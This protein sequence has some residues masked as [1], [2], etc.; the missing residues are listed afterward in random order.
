MGLLTLAGF[1]GW[2]EESG[3]G[4]GGITCTVHT[5]NDVERLYIRMRLFKKNI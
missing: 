4:E 2:G 5:A 1:F 3:V